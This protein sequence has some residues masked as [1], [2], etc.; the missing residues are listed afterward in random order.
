MASKSK[1]PNKFYITTTAPYVNAKP[2]IGFALEIIQA[3]AIARYKRLLGFDVFFNFG[4]DEHGQKIY[5]KAMDANQKPQE[6]VDEYAKKFDALKAALNLSYTKLTR[7]TDEHHIKAAQ[8]MWRLCDKNGFIKKGIYEAKY[9]VGCELEKQDSELENGKCPLHPNQ[10]IEIINEENYFFAFSKLQQNLLDLY[11]KHPDFVIPTH[12]LKEIT[13]FVES[14]TKDFSISRLKDKMPWGIPVPG[15]DKHVMYVWFDALT[16]YISSI[17]W[18]EDSERFEKFWGTEATPKALQLAGK[19]NLRQQ[20]AMWQAMLMAAGLPTSKQILIHGFI[21][22]NGQKM[23]KSL[24]NVVDPVEY[25]EKYGTDALRY[26][27][28]AKI[29]PYEDSD[30]TRESFEQVYQSDL[31]NGLGNLVARVA[32]LCENSK[33]DFPINKDL[34]LEGHIIRQMEKYRADK[35]IAVVWQ[36]IELTDQYISQK[37]PWNKEGSEL[38]SIL[39]VCVAEI[40]QIAHDLKV[41]LPSTAEKIEKQFLC[42][43]IKARDILFPRLGSD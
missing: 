10:D 8:E 37:E 35:A 32:K 27:L 24:G 38:K 15:D 9:C 42:T 26:Y 40:R 11:R 21:T 20:T 7:T 43:E 25:A 22:S 41:F 34:A 12:R 13:K 17:G 2:H 28:L 16:Y 23:S 39:N 19:D 6:Y 5:Q 36:K 18:P 4:T 14:G 33:M 31:A 29:S 3:D 1:E 30:F